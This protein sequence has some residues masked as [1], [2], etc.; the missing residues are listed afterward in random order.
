MPIK[1][2]L[3][4]YLEDGIFELRT[5]FAR[6]IARSVY[7]YQKGA[8]IILTHDF[9]KK[10]EKTPRKEIERAKKLRSLYHK[11]KEKV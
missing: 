5:A 10:T 8:K 11:G 9:I 1:E 2:S 3:S 7:I 6:K 4:K